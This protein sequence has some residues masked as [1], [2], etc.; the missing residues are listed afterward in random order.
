MDEK[1]LN[2]IFAAF[3]AETKQ[4][5]VD[6]TV[7]TASDEGGCQHT[8]EI[9]GQ[10]GEA[11]C[12]ACGLVSGE[13]PQICDRSDHI[14]PVGYDEWRLLTVKR[15]RVS[16]NRLNYLRQKL[17]DIMCLDN[18]TMT[19]T[20]EVLA[21]IRAQMTKDTRARPTR[22]AVVT[23]I[24]KIPEFRRMKLCQASSRITLMLQDKPIPRALTHTQVDQLEQLFLSIPPIADPLRRNC[25]NY[26]YLIYRLCQLLHYP[27]LLPYIQLPKTPRVI[28]AYN[29]LWADIC[30]AKGWRL[31]KLP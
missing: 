23:A 3:Y 21:K 5:E 27:W 30:T 20:R 1:L 28:D 9:L 19:I 17:Y 7:P 31:T 2:E 22:R 13:R 8:T 11:T 15:Q 16:H 14:G 26:E 10:D 18:V 24:N 29:R 4:L 25:L 6:Q 12:A